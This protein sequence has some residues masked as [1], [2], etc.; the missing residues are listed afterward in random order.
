[1]GFV[2]RLRADHYTGIGEVRTIRL[3]DGSTLELNTD[4]AVI[5]RFSQAERRV[6]LLRGEAF[7]D[8]ARNP[9]RPFVVE[10]S[11]LSATALGTRYG[12]RAPDGSFSGSVG[13]ESGRVAVAG[14][15]DRAVLRAGE[16]AGVTAQGQLGVRQADIS[17]ETAWRSGK[18]VFSNRPLREVMAALE[19][20]RHGR[21]V[22]MDDK[23]A[24]QLVSGIFDLNDTDDALRVLEEN[25]PVSI[26][27]VTGIMTIVR[28]N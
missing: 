24:E 6:L 23:A 8:V 28:S 5:V 22:V 7:F 25:L 14:G 12:V 19:R 17:N 20:Y 18:L 4:S 26:I 9:D 10:A 1:M 16:A 27:R 11:M 13:V 2:D 15:H 21:I 3:A